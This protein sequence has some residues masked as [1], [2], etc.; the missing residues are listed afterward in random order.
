MFIDF[1]LFCGSKFLFR[2][3]C[4]AQEH[5]KYLLHVMK[6]LK[7]KKKTQLKTVDFNIK[8]FFLFKIQ[9]NIN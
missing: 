5:L 9:K 8:H 4:T 3:S 2:K 6:I 7:L 1:T